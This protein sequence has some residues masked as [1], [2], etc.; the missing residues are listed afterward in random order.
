MNWIKIILFIC[1]QPLLI[2]S[3]A[4]F[5]SDIDTVVDLLPR[6]SDLSG[7]NR[8]I[9]PSEYN[10]NSV[11]RYNINYDNTGIEKLSYCEFFSDVNENNLIRV[12]I[13][14]FDSIINA[15]GFFSSKRG[16]GKLELKTVNEFYN[17]LY[18][19]AQRGEYIIYV[20][21]VKGSGAMKDVCAGF[22]NISIKNISENYNHGIIPSKA[23]IL[24]ADNKY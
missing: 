5:Q 3:C 20:Y 10:S 4:L 21:V 6:N 18:A 9:A 15:Y 13:L 12:E 8:T 2:I 24:L 16:E 19:V 7:W 23:G 11:K 17:N 1:I 14:R 22:L